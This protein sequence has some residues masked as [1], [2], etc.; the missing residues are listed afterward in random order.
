[1]I[2][3]SRSSRPAFRVAGRTL[4]RALVAPACAALLLAGA[5]AGRAQEPS[6][7][8]AL[9]EAARAHAAGDLDR[10]HAL[11]TAYLADHPRDADA[12]VLLARVQMDRGEWSDAYL[13]ISRAARAHPSDVDAL[14]YLGVVTRQLAA[15]QFARLA[16]MAPDSARVHQLRAETFEAQERR[17]DAEKAYAAALA[18]QPD[19]LEARLGLAR[20]QRIRLACDEAIAH[21]RRAEAIAPT[22]EG[23]YG[24]GV[25]HSY[26]QD[27]ETAVKHFEQA[28]ER[29][30]SEA[31]AWSGLGTSLVRLRRTAEGISKLE[32]A[33]ALEPRMSEAHYMLGMA[34]QAA[35]ETARAQSAFK[36]AE[37]LRA[38]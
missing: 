32:R 8:G 11:A 34:Y 16:A 13:V 26:L 5:E 28:I 18:A 23:A 3:F 21:Y 15:G 29:S 27:E 6:P 19:L 1:V 33:I 14:Y 22:F 20:L 37:E 10:A 24:L 9:A 2:P 17:A 25:C 31:V 12:Q 35:G 36:K 38:R 7:A 4:V 30:P